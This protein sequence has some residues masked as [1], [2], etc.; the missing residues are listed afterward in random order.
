MR[1]SP[2][3]SLLRSV[4]N[5]WIDDPDLSV[6]YA[7]MVEGKWAVRMAQETRDFTT[8]WFTPDQRTLRYEAYVLPAPRKDVEDVY[9]QCLFRNQ[10]SW[11]VRFTLKPDGG[12]Y[13]EGR[14]ANEQ[15]SDSE[16]GYVIAEIYQLIELS[17]R[18][19]LNAGFDR[20]Q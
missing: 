4:I 19:L 8:V 18:P 11:R 3:E 14:I 6:E 16:L 17:F 12:I 5:Q 2:I 9:R 15:V 7:E 1:A 13:L 10:N 20:G